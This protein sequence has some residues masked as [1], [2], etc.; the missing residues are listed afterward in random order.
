MNGLE[1]TQQ[2]LDSLPRPYP[3]PVDMTEESTLNHTVIGRRFEM[4]SEMYRVVKCDCCGF[5]KPGHDYPASPTGVVFER[6]H[7]LNK[8][9]PEFHC[10]RKE[11]CKGSQFYCAN[12]PTHKY[13]FYQQ[14]PSH[15]RDLLNLP[16]GE[17]NATICND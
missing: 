12:R 17:T 1:K 6:T 16:P 10:S 9:H 15:P 14:H 5:V 4:S 11:F 8:M 3:S 2:L 13:W 7:L